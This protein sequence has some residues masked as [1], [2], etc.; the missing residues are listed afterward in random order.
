MTRH[1][2]NLG[3]EFNVSLS[4]DEGGYLG[5]ECPE[6]ACG[7]YFKIKPGTGLKEED[8][9]LHCPYCGRQGRMGDFHTQA[10][11]DYALSV[12]HRQVTGAI[13]RD[14]KDMARDFN[15]RTR[16]RLLSV[17]MDV[18]SSPSPLRY[19]AEQKLETN[20]ECCNCTLQY[21]VYGVFAFCP[22]CRQRNSLQI[23]D[24]NLELVGKM[25]DMA[26]TAE[27]EVAE[28]LVENALEDCVSAFDGFGREVCRVHAKQ[29]TD[30]AK[31]EKVSFQNLDGAR[32]HLTELFGLDLA[33]GLT[34]EEW[35]AA[36]RGFQ[37]RHLLSHKMGVVD[38]EYIRKS[39]DTEAV[40][41][42]KVSIGADK[43]QQLIQVIGILARSAS[44][45]L[46][47]LEKNP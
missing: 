10:Q 34:D 39:G 21:S 8:L 2:R 9:P 37:K 5:R 46:Q 16:G 6:K 43:V 19:Y 23:L 42:R 24:K 40:V 26:T 45:G 12:V 20:V 35:K 47:R 14:L 22:D 33:A 31:V 1:L 29:S 13:G 4:V 25:L 3:S 27:A 18:K 17:K 15:R 32:Q 7:R 38:E 44:D 28:R 36:L 30:P 41:G 11:A